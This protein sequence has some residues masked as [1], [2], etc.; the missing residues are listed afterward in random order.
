MNKKVIHSVFERVAAAYPDAIAIETGVAAITYG[1]LNALANR[2]ANLLRWI[3]CNRGRIVNVVLPPSIPLV[4]TLLAV[5]KCGGIYLPVD[6]AFS[7]KRLA[8]VFRET[9]DGIIVV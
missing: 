6:W 7:R 5:F 8:Q 2:L 4:E 9:F 3:G 1:E